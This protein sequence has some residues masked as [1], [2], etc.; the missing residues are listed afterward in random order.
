VGILKIS[1]LVTVVTVVTVVTATEGQSVFVYSAAV[2]T[3]DVLIKM[4]V[5]NTCFAFID[6]IA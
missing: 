4:S 3:H 5:K 2:Q 6:I 1:A